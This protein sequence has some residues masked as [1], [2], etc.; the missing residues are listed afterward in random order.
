MKSAQIKSIG[1]ILFGFGSLFLGLEMMSDAAKPLSEL[2]GVRNLFVVL[3]SSPLLGI[4]TGAIVTAIIQSS[5][6]S[7]GI[8]QALALAGLVPWGSAIYIILGQNI[9]TYITAILSSIGANINA[10]RAAVIH[11][12]FNFIGSII[13][14]IIAIIIFNGIH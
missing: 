2:E 4:A 5:S 7:V 11:F 3:G 9:G 13:I 14:G 10:K 8:L 6:A 1:Q 12:L